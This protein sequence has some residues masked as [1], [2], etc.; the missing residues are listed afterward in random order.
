MICEDCSAVGLHGLKPCAPQGVGASCSAKEGELAH[1]S[2]DYCTLLAVPTAGCVVLDLTMDMA[3][4]LLATT[5]V[6]TL[7]RLSK[8][9]T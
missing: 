1:G 2:R 4:T 5:I 6:T 7:L 9:A 8:P 3:P